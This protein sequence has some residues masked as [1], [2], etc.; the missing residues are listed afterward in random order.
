MGRAAAVSQ[1]E[2][3]SGGVG[4]GV[5]GDEPRKSAGPISAPSALA[6]PFVFECA[7]KSKKPAG[8]RWRA[9]YQSR[10]KS[11]SR[12]IAASAHVNE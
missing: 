11:A 8:S 1:G 10:E 7:T 12:A 6:H 4:E 2:V 3:H 9:N 5:H